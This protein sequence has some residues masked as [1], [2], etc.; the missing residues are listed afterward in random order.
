MASADEAVDVVCRYYTAINA[1]DYQV[2][3]DQ[4]GESGPPNQTY[5]DFVDGY[6]QT[7]KVTVEVTDD[8]R[9]EGAAGSLYAT[10]P[11]TI[12]A[13]LRDGHIQHFF[14]HYIV[15]RVN[16]VPGASAAQLRWHLEG[17]NLRQAH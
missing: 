17:A 2:A 10:V 8:V 14:G 3:F 16:D 11:V 4:W 12:R 5:D 7:E 1:G 15:H 13:E 9:V 6:D